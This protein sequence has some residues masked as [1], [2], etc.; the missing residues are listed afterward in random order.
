MK[1]SEIIEALESVDP[2]SEVMIDNLSHQYMR[3]IH[4]V[5][6][7]DD[8]GCVAAMM[9]GHSVKYNKGL[10]NRVFIVEGG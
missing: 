7:S 8:D 5:V 2:D 6:V 1:A 4:H 3:S 10:P 9:Q